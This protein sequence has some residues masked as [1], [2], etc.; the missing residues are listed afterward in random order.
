MEVEFITFGEAAKRIG[1]PAPTL[2][3][4]TDKFEELDVHYLERNDKGERLFFDIDLEI[5]SY[6]K[7][8]KAHYGDRKAT[9]T[10]CA[11]HIAEHEKFRDRL[12]RR[13]P[14]LEILKRRVTNINEIDVNYLM[15]N[16]Q[17]LELLN[18]NLQMMR[19]QIKEEVKQEIATT[20]AKEVEERMS[21]KLEEIE[22]KRIRKFEEYIAKQR[23][24]HQEQME[25]LQ[26][27]WWKKL[28]GK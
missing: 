18:Q 2:R 25:L 3:G 7:E 22:E 23:E 17:F 24:M 15:S 21:A 4:W 28:L 11:Y 26:K 5:F 9:T 19:E 20:I 14:D 13:K 12:R 8:L 27:P 10:D 6:V 1:V 16:E